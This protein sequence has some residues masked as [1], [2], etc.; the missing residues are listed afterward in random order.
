VLLKKSKGILIVRQKIRLEIL[1]IKY[2]GLG[3]ASIKHTGNE[4]MANMVFNILAEKK[5]SGVC[6]P[7]SRPIFSEPKIYQQIFPTARETNSCPDLA[8]CPF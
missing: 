2:L 8:Q 3:N 6:K 1:S 5:Y 4:A 7:I